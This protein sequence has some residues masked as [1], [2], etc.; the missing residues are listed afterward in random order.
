MLAKYAMAYFVLGAAL[1]ALTDEGARKL[2]WRPALW[3][4][5]LIAAVIVAPN[6][7]WNALNGL[8]TV[9][10]TGLNIEG[11]GFELSIGKGLEFILSQF[12]VIGPVVFGIFLVLIVRMPW[13]TLPRA[14]RLLMSF[15]TPPLVLVTVVAFA[16]GANAN[17]AAPAFVPAAVVATAVMVRRKFWGLLTASLCIGLAAQ[18]LLVV[19]DA[20]ADRLTLPL[21]SKNADIYRKTMAGRSLGEAVGGFARRFET[22]TVVAEE[23]YELSLL[24]YYL[25][26]D[27][28]HAFL[29]PSGAAPESYYDVEYVLLNDAPRPILLVSQ[30]PVAARLA[31]YY[32]DVE[33]LGRFDIRTGPTSARFF[34][35]FKLDRPRGPIGPLAKC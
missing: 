19:G 25:R 34:F 7:A 15:A 33:P 30:C 27:H 18:L 21:L 31:Q 16:H 6:V 3:L 4:A 2:L 5:V 8:A 24:L 12:V 13:R 9:K 17:W 1:A 23:H 20:M 11:N 26:N 22:P 29:W 32:E 14:D 35:A 28:L 10:H